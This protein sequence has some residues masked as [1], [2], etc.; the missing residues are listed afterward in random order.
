MG[1]PSSAVL[2]L[3]SIGSHVVPDRD[4]AMLAMLPR[5]LTLEARWCGACQSTEVEQHGDPAGHL[6]RNFEIVICFQ[7]R[8]NGR[9]ISFDAHKKD[10]WPM[11]AADPNPQAESTSSSNRK[12]PMNYFDLFP[13]LG[14]RASSPVV[15][16]EVVALAAAFWA[17][18]DERPSPPPGRPSNP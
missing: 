15:T 7:L 5:V 6:G 13:S 1:Q 18:D 11:L 9:S 2:G 17:M 12:D 8:G 16:Q 4:I 10:C 14:R 3:K